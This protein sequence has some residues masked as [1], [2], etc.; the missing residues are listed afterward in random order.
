MGPVVDVLADDLHR[1]RV[2]VGD[3]GSHFHDVEH[4]LVAIKQGEHVW[5]SQFIGLSL[6]LLQLKGV[7]DSLGHVVFLDWLFL[8]SAVV[9]YN[10]ELVP[11]EVELSAY[12]RGEVIIEAEDGAGTHD[13]HIGEG[14]PHYLLTV[15]LGLE[16]QGGRVGISP[17]C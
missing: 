4:D 12:Q 10:D 11:E 13:G 8:G 9:I 14:L 7:E 5:S 17:S 16:V 15:E 1:F 3:F 6:G 2:H